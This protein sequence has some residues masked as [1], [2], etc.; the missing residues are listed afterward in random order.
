MKKILITGPVLSQSGYGEMSRFAYRA[1]KSRPDLFD[2]YLLTTNWGT[3]GNIS[4]DD[5]LISSVFEDVYRTQKLLADNNKI[6]FDVSVQIS[7]P[8]EWKKIAPVNI[9][10][11]AGIET[12]LISPAWYMPS[13]LMDKIIV[14][15]EHAK[16]GFINTIFGDQGGNQFKVRTGVDVCHFPVKNCKDVE[17]DLE[18]KN[19][20]NF[21]SVCQWGPRKNLEQLIINFIEEFKDEDVGLVLK[22]NTTNDSIID[23]DLTEKRL[24][25]LLNNFSD[26]KCS[27]HL[28]HGNMSDDEI[29]ALYKHPKIKALVS[30]TH[31]EGFGFPMFEAAYNDLPVIAT[32]W[33]GHLD[34]L[35][36][37]DEEGVEKK[38]FAKVDYE[39]KPISDHHVWQGVLEKGTSWAYPSSTHLKTRMRDVYKDYNRF[40]SWAKKLG[41]YVRENFTEEKVNKQFIN[42]LG[43]SDKDIEWQKSLQELIEND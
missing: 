6:E 38:M 27:I 32:D 39:I 2:V 7:I 21:L 14:I 29:N 37:K 40:K 20:F 9:G 5:F 25:E 41:S 15:S 34:F 4:S 26:R 22:V 33:S 23:R 11:T 13:N 43:F 3:T 30:A 17:L 18:L 36:M 19:N 8:N 28:L 12:N 24:Q 42:A 35:T 31:G 1:L 16:S 10:Y